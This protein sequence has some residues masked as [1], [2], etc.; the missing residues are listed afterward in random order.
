MIP[1]ALA[2]WL[3][4]NMCMFPKYCDVEHIHGNAY[5]VE[6][7]HEEGPV[8]FMETRQVVING[9]EYALGINNHIQ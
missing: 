5:F 3:A 1:G 2:A 4:I 8:T 7:Y 6:V 9:V